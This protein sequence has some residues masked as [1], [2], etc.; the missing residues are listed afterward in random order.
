MF[1]KIVATAF[2]ALALIAAA[3]TA[4]ATKY[5]NGRQVQGTQLNGKKANGVQL[6]G[7]WPNGKKANGVSRA[8]NGFTFS[9]IELADGTTLDLLK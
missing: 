8:A 5:D 9:V 7:L 4:Q 2:A 6:N 3:G 1:T